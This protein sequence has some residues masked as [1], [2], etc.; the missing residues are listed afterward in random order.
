MNATVLPALVGSAAQLAL[1]DK[2][3]L[4]GRRQMFAASVVPAVAAIVAEMVADAPEFATAADAMMAKF[5]AL[6]ETQTGAGFWLDLADKGG[7]PAP[8]KPGTCDRTRRLE[9]ADNRDSVKRA[10][11]NIGEAM[12]TVLMGEYL[13]AGSLA[14][15]LA[16]VLA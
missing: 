5:G 16:P 9:A 8:A 13:P 4:D 12:V 10:S 7:A 6:V 3:N 14:Q 1:A 2:K 15:K 11:E